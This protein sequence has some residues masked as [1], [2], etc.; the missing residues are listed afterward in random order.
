MGGRVR[1]ALV[2]VIVLTVAG[3]SSQQIIDAPSV[4]MTVDAEDAY[5]TTKLRLAQP[6]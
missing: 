5:V 1:F 6:F 3:C 2:S 4:K